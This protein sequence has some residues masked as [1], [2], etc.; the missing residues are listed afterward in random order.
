MVT[1]ATARTFFTAALLPVFFAMNRAPFDASLTKCL[2][3]VGLRRL[4]PV[5]LAERL[6]EI[7]KPVQLVEGGAIGDTPVPGRLAVLDPTA[8]ATEIPDVAAITPHRVI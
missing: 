3:P 6:D 4:C 7:V 1:V 8:A 2:F 5:A